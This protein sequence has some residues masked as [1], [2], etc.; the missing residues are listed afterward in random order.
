MPSIADTFTSSRAFL[1]A[2]NAAD[3]FAPED[4]PFLRCYFLNKQ[5]TSS[6]LFQWLDKL[7]RGGLTRE[8][9]LSVVY[10][11][12][13]K[14][15]EHE[16][17]TSPKKRKYTRRAKTPTGDEDDTPDTTPETSP[18]RPRGKP[19]SAEEDEPVTPKARPKKKTNAPPPAKKPRGSKKETQVVSESDLDE[20]DEDDQDD[21]D[22]DERFEAVRRKL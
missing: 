6:F 2:I 14:P 12:D 5:G 18:T 21:E 15:E 17:P 8:Q 4:I 13:H 1:Q 19:R 3:K 20:E 11:A 7:E 10:G 22:D 16:Q 9:V